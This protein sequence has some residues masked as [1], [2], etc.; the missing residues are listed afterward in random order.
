MLRN[1]HKNITRTEVERRLNAF[2]INNVGEIK[3]REN[4]AEQNSKPLARKYAQN[5]RDNYT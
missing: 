1:S 2:Y 3:W 5:E 4:R